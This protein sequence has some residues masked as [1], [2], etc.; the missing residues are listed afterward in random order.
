MLQWYVFRSIK[1][2]PAWLEFCYSKV[3]NKSGSHSKLNL[4]QLSQKNL[5]E[6]LAIFC[7]PMDTKYDNTFRYSFK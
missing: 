7:G 5:D 1:V 4:P 3:I 2:I 6:I